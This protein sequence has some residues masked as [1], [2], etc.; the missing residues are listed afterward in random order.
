MIKYFKNKKDDLSI[1]I[2]IRVIRMA[3]IRVKINKFVLQAALH[4]AGVRCNMLTPLAIGNAPNAEW[5]TAV[6][7][8]GFKILKAFRIDF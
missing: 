1:I 2:F 3:K 6:E 7:K 4:N 8:W 5:L